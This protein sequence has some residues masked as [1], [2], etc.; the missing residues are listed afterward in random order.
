MANPTSLIF[1]GA[2]SPSTGYVMQATDTTEG[3]IAEFVGDDNMPDIRTNEYPLAHADGQKFVSSYWGAK[4]IKVV[5]VIKSVTASGLDGQVDNFKLNLYPRAIG[6]LVVG[7]GTGDRAYPAYVKSVIIQRDS[8]DITRVPFEVMFTCEQGFGQE[9]SYEAVTTFSGITAGSF[10]F[11]VL[12]SGT[13]P[14]TPKIQFNTVAASQLGNVSMQ[15]LASGDIITFARAFA[16]GDL[17]V[18][19]TDNQTV[20]VGGSGITYSG[21]M[22]SF[23]AVSGTNPIR[24][25]TAS[26]TQ[27]YAVSVI[28][29]PKFL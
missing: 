18:I 5:G 14:F 1:Y 22:P 3:I 23:L 8:V 11:N 19:D 10:Q 17:M 27:T 21:I 20:Q 29:R 15:N 26:G 28:Y 7:R 16:A 13:A 4:D 25:T 24:I 12:T 9:P 6:N 2:K